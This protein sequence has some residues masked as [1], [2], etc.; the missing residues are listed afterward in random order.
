MINFLTVLILYALVFSVSEL[1][2]RK[3]NLSFLLSRKI[4]HIAGS[5]VSFFLPCFITSTSAASVG[6]MFTLIIFISRKLCILKSIH[7]NKVASIGEVLYPLGIA[8]SALFIWPLSIIAYQGSCL[9]FG[10][11]DGLAGYIGEMY[12]KKSYF[13]LGGKKTVEGSTVFF[14][15]TA[16]IFIIYYFL[17]I[18]KISS[19]GILLLL[20]YSL[21][22]TILEALFSRGWDNLV[23]PITAGLA[24]FLIVS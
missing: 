6:V 20:F 15:F 24:L 2:Y 14:I 10:L 1:A 18:T 12:G 9:V 21:G 4:A 11:S 22:L 7:D 13:I 3:L 5:I 23:I 16:I 8:L 17:F 19:A